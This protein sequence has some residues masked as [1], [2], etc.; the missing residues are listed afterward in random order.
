MKSEEEIKI[1]EDKLNYIN[2]IYS[3][4][5]IFF[6]MREKTN[7]FVLLVISIYLDYEITDLKELFKKIHEICDIEISEL[8]DVFRIKEIDIRNN[9]QDIYADFMNTIISMHNISKNTI[10]NMVLDNRFW[11][12]TTNS[13]GRFAANILGQVPNAR[14]LDAYSGNGYFDCDYL[15]LNKTAIIDGYEI[16]PDCIAIAKAIN[17][18][19]NTQYESYKYG[20]I[21]NCNYLQ[22]DFLIANLNDNY[23]DLVFAD[24]PIGLRYDRNKIPNVGVASKFVKNNVISIPWL[25]ALKIEDS[26]NDNGKAVIVCPAGSLLGMVDKE[27]R[28]YFVDKNLISQIIELPENINLY[29][30]TKLYLIVIE[31]GKKDKTIK[32]SDISDCIIKERRVNKI[33][34]HEA[35]NKVHDNAVEIDIK[36]IEKNNY[37]LDVNRY[38]NNNKII[39]SDG[40]ELEKVAEKIFRG[41]Q[42]TASQIDEMFTLDEKKANYKIL[43]VSNINNLGYVDDNLKLI[44]SGTKD[45]SKHILQNGDIVLSSKG[46]NT[47]IAIIEDIEDGEYIIPSGSLIVIRLDRNK[48]I[49]MYLKAF[50]ESEIGQMVL[51]SA[52]TGIAMLSI[53]PSALLKTT[54]KCP[55]IQEQELFLDKYM[56]MYELCKI[57]EEKMNRY[58]KELKALIDQI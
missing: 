39:F 51:D 12:E 19:F 42:F 55:S 27:V 37:N 48:M 58:I 47:K 13:L 15:G 49:P 9:F 7:I 36:K 18:I 6:S 10:I 16:N 32:F 28:K 23:Y 44:N 2:G 54:V 21:I 52:K 38:I 35:L 22:T 5:G 26:L 14:L 41:Y 53:V 20:R 40:I 57:T 31:K 3:R 45:L 43:E 33:N 50:F 4:A 24:C 56:M 46:N 30:K 11:Y 29:S 8:E 25:T 34:I 17:Y 1:V